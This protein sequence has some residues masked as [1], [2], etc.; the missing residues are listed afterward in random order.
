MRVVLSLRAHPISNRLP[1]RRPVSDT[2]TSGRMISCSRVSSQLWVWMIESFVLNSVTSCHQG[3]CRFEVRHIM[4][5][6]APSED[7]PQRYQSQVVA[8][9][10]VTMDKANDRLPLW[11]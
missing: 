9:T 10:T 4:S 6:P 11:A 3:V 1:V 7:H 2:M 5:A 8:G